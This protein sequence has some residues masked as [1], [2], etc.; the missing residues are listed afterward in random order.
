MCLNE[1]YLFWYGAIIAF[2]EDMMKAV[3]FSAILTVLMS[4]SAQADLS[5]NA[6]LSCSEKAEAEYAYHT[7]VLIH[8]FELAKVSPKE[9]EKLRSQLVTRRENELNNCEQA[10]IAEME[11]K[12]DDQLEAA[13][14]A[15][16]RGLA[17]VP[18]SVIGTDRRGQPVYSSGARRGAYIEVGDS[19]ENC[20]D[21]DGGY[22]GGRVE[23]GN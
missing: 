16:T 10:Y 11:K 21:D 23:I 6:D 12:V 20:A 13:V 17:S 18:S 8:V 15:P 14:T 22:T 3:V 19:T 4:V 9:F 5:T 7:E 2:T 1:T